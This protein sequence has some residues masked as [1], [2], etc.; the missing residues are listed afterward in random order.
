[1]KIP[2]PDAL[3][4]WGLQTRVCYSEY[5]TSATM[6]QKTTSSGSTKRAEG[7]SDMPRA[8]RKRRAA[9]RAARCRAVGGTSVAKSVSS[10]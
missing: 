6:S 5:A 1:V 8:L 3:A 7:I 10:G 4:V 9:H 2:R